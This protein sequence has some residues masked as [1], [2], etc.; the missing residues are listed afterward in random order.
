MRSWRHTV[1]GWVQGWGPRSQCKTFCGQTFC[2]QTVCGQTVCGG[3]RFG[4]RTFGGLRP[5]GGGSRCTG[6]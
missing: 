5:D 3:Q 4:C 2:G 6:S 1:Q